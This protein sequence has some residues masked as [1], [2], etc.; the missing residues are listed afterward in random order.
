MNYS[1]QEMIIGYNF[2]GEVKKLHNIRGFNA[3]LILIKGVDILFDILFAKTFS[4]VFAI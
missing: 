3:C 1:T 4:I 2:F